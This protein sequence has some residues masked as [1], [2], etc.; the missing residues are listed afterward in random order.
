MLTKAGWAVAAA[1]MLAAILAAGGARA[2]VGL[3]GH[4]AV[5]ELTLK[6]SEGARAPAAA[7]G[8]IVFDL[9][10]SR[11][12][13]WTTTFRQVTDVT[14]SEGETRRSDMSATSHEEGDG[15][16]LRFRVQ[17]SEG[18]GDKVVQGAASRS[19]GGLSI[20]LTRPTRQKLDLGDEARFP[21]HQ[22]E[23]VI[24]A[25][26]AGRTTYEVKL[27]DGSDT[28]V[29]V[30][31]TLTVIGPAR[32]E[33]AKEAAAQ[34]ASLKGRKRWPVTTSYFEPGAGD[35]A[36]VYT[37]SFDL[38]DNGVSR[39]LTLDYGTFALAGELREFKV[40]EGKGCR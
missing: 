2:E 20:A 12:E 4:R 26:L 22:T 37:L 13:G 38:Y 6:S 31:D 21:I 34:D 18:H 35:R 15:S 5:Y 36:P 1:A 9:Q 23:G 3:I 10:G 32:A 40:Y 24:E 14:P 27:F 25:A 16:G 28:G 33:D 39:N 30:Y 11:C 29:K 19:D 17:T 8:M 7:R